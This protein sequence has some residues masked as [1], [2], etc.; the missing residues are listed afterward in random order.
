MATTNN[1]NNT[2]NTNSAIRVKLNV[3]VNSLQ[4]VIMAI[5]RLASE[6]QDKDAR[7]IADILGINA[8]SVK[9][10]AERNKLRLEILKRIPALKN[11][12]E[13]ATPAKLTTKKIG[14]EQYFVATETSWVNAVIAAT[15]NT[16]NRQVK[17]TVNNI[18]WEKVDGKE[19]N[20]VDEK[21]TVIA[22]YDAEG[23]DITAAN[24]QAVR[25]IIHD[26]EAKRVANRVA[27]VKRGEVYAEQIKMLSGE[28]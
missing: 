28:K 18:V 25:A 11:G 10:R 24:P 2:K 23:N 14:G 12:A 21:K 3:E 1:T 6:I 9:N 16:E 5:Y 4:A 22:L 20:T 7:R 26:A 19:T 13:V 17:L 15:E 8:A 27:A